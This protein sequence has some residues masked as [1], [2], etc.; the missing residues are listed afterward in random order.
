MKQNRLWRH[1][2]AAMATAD[3]EAAR[4]ELRALVDPPSDAVADA[5]RRLCTSR[6]ADE[7]RAG[8]LLVDE[9]LAARPDH[10]DAASLRALLG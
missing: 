9:L 10:A 1:V 6:R 3:D 7:R 8:R 5:A 4:S 2:A